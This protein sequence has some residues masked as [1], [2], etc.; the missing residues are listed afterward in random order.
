MSPKMLRYGATIFLAA[1]LLFI[2]YQWL[3]QG[4]DREAAPPATPGAQPVAV[5][6]ETFQTAPA[7]PRETV[8]EEAQ[9]TI[10]EYR[11]RIET[12][13]D[14]EEKPAL[15]MA[16]GNLYQQRLM[17][18]REAANCYQ[19]YILEYPE[20]PDLALAYTQLGTCY[21]LLGDGVNANRIYLE[22]ME[23]F[24]DDSQEHLYAK[25]KLGL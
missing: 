14:A 8:R 17:D 20:A 9:R 10:E 22:M 23:R 1:V 3:S 12:A 5:S 25:D 7:A 11:E 15:L 2:M 16:M 19:V 24:P 4:P 13:P 6:P 18:Y 21:E